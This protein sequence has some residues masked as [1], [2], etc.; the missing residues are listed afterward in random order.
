MYF[1]KS[2]QFSI[3]TRIS[4]GKVNLARLKTAFPTECVCVCVKVCVYQCVCF[5]WNKERESRFTSISKS[6][7]E[8]EEEDGVFKRGNVFQPQPSF[9]SSKLRRNFADFSSDIQENE[10][11]IDHRTIGLPSQIS[12]LTGTSQW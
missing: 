11:Y 7:R 1:N 12:G 10:S 2:F 5:R 8:E 3:L 6:M 9:E 4:Q